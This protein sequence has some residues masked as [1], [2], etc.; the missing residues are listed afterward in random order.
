MS[1]H[2]QVLKIYVKFDDLKA[3][4]KASSHNNLGRSNMWVPIERSQ[5]TFTLKKKIKSSVAVTRIQFPLTLSY[6]C[7]F[8]KVQG[9]SS[10]KVVAT[11]NLC[12]QKAFQPG[13]AYVALRRITNFEGLYL[14]GSYNRALIKTN[15][16]AKYEYKRPKLQ[17]RFTPV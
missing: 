13:Q 11:L 10:S 6:V 8:H 15:V 3:G 9:T 16:A 2:Q 5:A 17:Q 4:I 12:K 1:N 7:T 14:T